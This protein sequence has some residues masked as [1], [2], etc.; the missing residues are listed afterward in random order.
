MRFKSIFILLFVLT[1]SFSSNAFAEYQYMRLTDTPSDESGDFSLNNYG[2]LAWNYQNNLFMFDFETSNTYQFSSQSIDAG[3]HLLDDGRMLWS[4]DD[5]NDWDLWF[6][7]GSTS[8]PLFE[9]TTDNGLN[10]V[11]AEMNSYGD[12]AWTQKVPYSQYMINDMLLYDSSAG[13]T[14]RLD[15]WGT[16]ARINENEQ[17]VW[18]TPTEV[19]LYDGAIPPETI[20]TASRLEAVPKMNNDGDVVYSAWDGNDYEIYLKQKEADAPIQI[21]NDDADDRRPDIN[22]SGDIVWDKDMDNSRSIEKYNINTQLS[23]TFHYMGIYPQINNN[24]D[25]AFLDG[26]NGNWDVSL[27]KNDAVSPVTKKYY[28]ILIGMDYYDP[29]NPEGQ[30]WEK[31]ADSMLLGLNRYDGWY[32][33]E[34]NL[35]YSPDKHHI[36]GI[37]KDIEQEIKPGDEFLFYYSGH[38]TIRDHEGHEYNPEP[39]IIIKNFEITDSQ[40]QTITVNLPTDHDEALALNHNEYLL[41]DELE[42]LFDT[43]IWESV[44]KTMIFNNCLAGGFWLNMGADFTNPFL[45]NRDLVSVANTRFLAASREDQLTYGIHEYLIDYLESGEGVL[46]YE[47]WFKYVL[48]NTP[49]YQSFVAIKSDFDYSKL[50]SFYSNPI[51]FSNI[52]GDRYWANEY[53]PSSSTVPEPSTVVLLTSGLLGLIGLRKKKKYEKLF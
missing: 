9:S 35:L 8:Y 6:Y 29:K 5:G 40:G 16:N 23:D 43:E 15:T 42:M 14:T 7:D 12:I 3:P 38:G 34:I 20:A 48:E 44:E 17:V 26:A 21:T 49:E 1:I 45:D 52:E 53:G 39:E 13:T 25:I 19:K 2:D 18:A 10:D 28:A 36:E 11:D 50:Y 37:I 22:D 27:L 46:S 4:R 31:E 32:D 30:K 51:Y 41:D 33:A 47:E 24:G